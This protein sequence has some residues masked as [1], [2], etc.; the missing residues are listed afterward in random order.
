M[1]GPTMD[2]SGLSFT[3][4]NIDVDMELAARYG[5]RSVPT[6]L[7]VDNEGNEVKRLVGNQDLK[8]IKNWYNG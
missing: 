1:L 7:V 4:V 6:L 3:K 5:V 2:Q 8:T